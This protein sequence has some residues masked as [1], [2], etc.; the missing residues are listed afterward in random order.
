MRLIRRVIGFFEPDE[1]IV[2]GTML[3]VGFLFLAIVFGANT[4]SCPNC[5]HYTSGHH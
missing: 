5:P 2:L 4:V 1:W 3:I